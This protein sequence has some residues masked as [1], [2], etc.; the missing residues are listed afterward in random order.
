MTMLVTMYPTPGP[1]LFH[2]FAKCRIDQVANNPRQKDDKSIY[3]ALNQGHGD[4]VTISNVRD[5][6]SQYR[7]NLFP[8]HSL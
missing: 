4:H 5:F 8:R 1:L 6:V 3:Y 7:F 2:H